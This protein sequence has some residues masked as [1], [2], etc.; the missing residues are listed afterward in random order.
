MCPDGDASRSGSADGGDTGQELKQEP[1]AQDDERRDG[2]EENKDERQNTGAREKNNVG[3]HDS[4]DGAAGSERGKS[5]VKVEND[6]GEAGA[7]AASEVEEKIGEVAEVVLHVVAEDPK[8]EHVSGDVQEAAMQEHAGEDGEEGGLDVSV[9]VE[10]QADV[11]G[12][13]GVGHDEGLILVG[14]ERELIEKDDDVRQNEERVDDGV[15]L[16]RII[17]FE[18]DEHSRVWLG[19]LA[20]GSVLRCD[21]GHNRF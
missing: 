13:G 18:R 4:R 7:D 14:R 8:E 21:A 19:Y 5:R 15:G 2:N 11:R 17:V 12:D 3:A 10:G 6:V 9:A 1:I 20:Q 16:A